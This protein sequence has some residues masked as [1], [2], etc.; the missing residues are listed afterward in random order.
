VYALATARGEPPPFDEPPGSRRRAAQAACAH[1]RRAHGMG[2]CPD[3]G[4]AA[5]REVGNEDPECDACGAP[6]HARFNHCFACGA[7]F[8]EDNAPD[9]GAEGYVL[10]YDCAA[11]DCDGQV[12]AHMAHCPWCGRA[13]P[14]PRAEDD[15]DCSRCQAVL[16]ATWAF[17]A[18][19]GEEAPLP[20]HCASCGD[21]LARAA[22]AARCEEC[23]HLVCG[24]CFDDYTLPDAAERGE[25]LLCLGCAEQLDAEPVASEDDDEGAEAEDTEDEDASDEDASDEDASD[26][27]ASDED[28]SAGAEDPESSDAGDFTDEDTDAAASDDEAPEEDGA[29]DGGSTG[30]AS[31]T[32]A[33]DGPD[34][35]AQQ[36]AGGHARPGAPPPGRAQAAPPPPEDSSEDTPASPWEVLGVAPGTPL[37]D[38]KRAYLT[39]VA[40]YHPDKV[41]ALGPKLQRVALEETRRLNLAWSELRER[42]R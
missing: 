23:R 33:G 16:D 22:C 27:D 42:A 7:S 10:E 5:A 36:D 15:A 35:R 39:L 1:A 21:A 34:A 11:R 28:A 24:E 6:S 4:A 41:A 3:C 19:C 8:G 13:Q 17:C 38:V 37:P 14:W 9:E 26:E 32:A 20:E 31:R 40:Q 25:L 12:A 30:P 2:F 18:A 29:D